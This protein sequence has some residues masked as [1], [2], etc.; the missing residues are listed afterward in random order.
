MSNV[1]DLERKR[2]H[3]LN[4]SNSAGCLQVRADVAHSELFRDLKRVTEK[5]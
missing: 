5:N 2:A 1:A 3:K 4:Q